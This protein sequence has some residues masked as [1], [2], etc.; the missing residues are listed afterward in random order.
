MRYIGG[1]GFWSELTP[2]GYQPT[3]PAGRRDREEEIR[4]QRTEIRGQRTEIRGQRSE[5]RGQRSEDR[6]QRS[7]IRNQKAGG[8]WFCVEGVV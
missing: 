3:R 7:E 8:Y 5:D 2:T 1:S 6:G 4:G